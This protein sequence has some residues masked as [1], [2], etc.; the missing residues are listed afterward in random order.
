MATMLLM[1]VCSF[2][3]NSNTPLKGDVN[4]DG[5]V[6]V[7]DI[8]AILK[9]MKDP[10]INLNPSTNQV[11]TEPITITSTVTNGVPANTN[12]TITNEGASGQTFTKSTST[13]ASVVIT[14]NDMTAPT[15]DT[16]TVSMSTGSS[17]QSTSSGTIALN[18]SFTP[19]QSNTKEY[20]TTLTASYIGVTPKSIDIT[21]RKTTNPLSAGT[22]EWTVVGNLPSGVQLS[23]NTGPF[24]SLINTN[25][26]SVQIAANTIKVTNANATNEAYNTEIITVPGKS[27]TNTYYWYAGQT[28]PSTM[29]SI[30]PIVTS[31]N[32]GGGWYELGTT[33]PE[34]ITQLVKGG[35]STKYWYVA[36]PIT[37]G[38][39]LKPV[40]S[41][42]TTLDT[43][44]ST[45][46]T[47]S[48]NGISYQ[49]YW[50]GGATAARNT[51][52]LA[53]K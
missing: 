18:G 50:Y 47:K 51:F 1:S 29:S 14:P 32:D 15:A 20:T 45:Q 24:A 11:I 36:V 49:I 9:I 53:K 37:S 42:M 6:D 30:S 38:T 39:T 41:D 44:V 40:A 28:N 8:V 25:S 26:S 43:S 16:G 46:S 13:G 10:V 48:F 2:A 35:D 12:W 5:K 33:V 19:G 4:G 17:S 52:T 21:F 27:E 22:Y 34:T 7:A 23:S 31:Y 3:Q